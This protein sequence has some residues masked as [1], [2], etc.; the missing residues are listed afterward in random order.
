MKTKIQK[1]IKLLQDKNKNDRKYLRDQE[2][3]F[4]NCEPEEQ[5]GEEIQRAHG[6]IDARES[7]IRSLKTILRV[8]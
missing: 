3:A 8:G 5:I 4:E 1:F 7:V 6:G 2:E